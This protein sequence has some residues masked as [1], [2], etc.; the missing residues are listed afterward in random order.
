MQIAIKIFSQTRFKHLLF[1]VI[2]LCVLEN[3][4]FAQKLLSRK[5]NVVF[6]EKSIEEVV[7][8]LQNY[9]GVSFSYSRN[10]IQFDEKVSGNFKNED[11]KT[12]LDEV[13]KQ[14]S[15]VYRYK[16]GMIILSPKPQN[17]DNI[18]ITGIIKSIDNNLPIEYAGV[19]ISSSEKGTITDI[20]GKF[21][22]IIKNYE[23]NDTLKISSLGFQRA[24]YIV[25]NFANNSEYIVYLKRRI[26]NLKEVKVNASDYKTYTLGNKSKISFG[27]I[28]IDTQ[29][30]QTALFIKNK[31]QKEGVL[32]S[33][34]FYLSR[35]GNVNSPF[36][37][38]VYKCK[39]Y[40]LMPGEN[41]LS[42]VIIAK[43]KN[44]G[45]WF[46]VDLFQFNITV[47]KEGFF[48]AIEGIFPYDYLKES[49]G[50]QD[51]LDNDGDI[52]PNSI[53]YGQRLGYSRKKG[54]NTWHYSLAH[55]WFQLK[56]QNYNVMISAEIQVR[57]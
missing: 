48:I 10:L 12:V 27:S 42:E 7:K 56:E 8:Y 37:I 46:K 20:N 3:Q 6:K 57:K 15:V 29:G 35:K 44:K 1:F 36:R 50:F 23:I 54:K 24:S 53:S 39:E 2:L 19:Q 43:P 28:Y 26:I 51:V 9:E 41:L 30:Q 45:A 49:V 4:L 14:S 32:S 34:S 21:S 16:A 11:L 33:V 31:K 25:S 13:F 5:I 47:P 18:L 40:G 17:V 52:M 55:T 22:M 38:R